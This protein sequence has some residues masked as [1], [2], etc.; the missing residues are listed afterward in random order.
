[1][2]ELGYV[3][4]RTVTFEARSADGRFELVVNLQT[5]EKLG[6]T[7]PQSILLIADETIR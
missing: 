2:R 7:V 3:E 1:M 4:G 5:A 6:F